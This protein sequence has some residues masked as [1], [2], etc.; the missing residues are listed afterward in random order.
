MARRR[1]VGTYGGFAY[2]APLCGIPALSYYSE[3]NSFSTRHLDLMRD[4]LQ[5]RNDARLLDV[6][7]VPEERGPVRRVVARWRSHVASDA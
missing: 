5:S 6:V 3:A 4:V 1:F 2:L 7:A